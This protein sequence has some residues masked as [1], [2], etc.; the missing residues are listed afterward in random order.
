MGN[1]DMKEKGSLTLAIGELFHC[2][3]L[4]TMLFSQH[5]QGMERATVERWMGMRG[6]GPDKQ[7]YIDE[8]EKDL[9]ERRVQGRQTREKA[10]KK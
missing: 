5:A 7:W 9:K 4:S 2:P 1:M 8:K 10:K 3:S 6:S